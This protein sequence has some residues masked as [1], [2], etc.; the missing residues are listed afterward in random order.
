M[1]AHYTLL[2]LAI[3]PLALSQGTEKTVKT[4]TG[5]V[6]LHFFTSGQISTKTWTDAMDRWGHC[7][8]YDRSG[9]VIFDRQTRRVGGH[10]RVDFRYHPNGAVSHADVSD[11]PDGGIQWYQST[12]TF[13]PD[14]QQ[15]GFSEQ[16]WDNNGPIGPRLPPATS[17]AFKQKEVQEQ[18]LYT[19]EYFVVAKKNCRVQLR[20]KQKSPASK[21]LD[22][23]LL[24]GDTLRGGA[25][26]IGERFAPPL[27]QVDVTITNRKGKSKY[28]VLRTDSVQVD[29]EHRRWY[30]LVG[31]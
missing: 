10:A 12:T 9:K 27:G 3:A 20:P 14:G 15:T 23:T 31:R 2:A 28:K 26:S 6:V 24:K 21:D 18:R 8:A 4:D 11:A 13:D 7:W 17:P 22:A 25:Y 16:G 5:T 29:P 19:N 30:L 1:R